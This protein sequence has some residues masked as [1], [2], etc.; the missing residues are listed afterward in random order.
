M[1]MRLRNE[2]RHTDAVKCLKHCAWKHYYQKQKKVVQII[3]TITVLMDF[4][5]KL[6]FL[7]NI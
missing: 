1:T 5:C 3:M 7:K 6:I 2:K 4:C